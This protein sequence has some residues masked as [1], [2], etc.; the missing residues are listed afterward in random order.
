[1]FHLDEWQAF[2]KALG[3]TPPNHKTI[4]TTLLDSVHAKVKAKVDLVMAQSPE[5]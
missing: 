2:F 3:Y 5:L 1:M 4:S